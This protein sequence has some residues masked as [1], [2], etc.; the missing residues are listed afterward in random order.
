MAKQATNYNLAPLRNVSSFLTLAKRLQNRGAGLPGMGCFYGPSGY[1]KTTAS[2]YSANELDAC[3]VQCKSVWTQKKLCQT[4]CLELGLHPAKSI[5][6]MVDQISE[7][8]ARNRRPLIIDEAD[9]LVQKRMI[10]IVRDMYESSFVP[11]ILIGEELLPQ[12]L[13]RWERVHG[14]ILSW[15]A[16]EPANDTD[17]ALLQ[18]IRCPG[19]DLAPELVAQMKVA[20]KGS[21]RRIVEN[22]ELAREIAA[23]QGLDHVGLKEWNGRSFFAGQT[24]APRRGVA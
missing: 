11:V 22:L 8:L 20:S 23:L 14:R 7:A 12:K 5:A 6:D 10:E 3:A 19:I 1:G 16:A 18:K 15:V 13:A 9:F 17:F 4:I 21:A 24:P 2:L